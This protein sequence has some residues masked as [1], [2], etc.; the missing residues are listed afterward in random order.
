MYGAT[1]SICRLSFK[2][3]VDDDVTHPHFRIIY[4]IRPKPRPSRGKLRGYKHNSAIYYEYPGDKQPNPY[5]PQAYKHPHNAYNGYMDIMNENLVEENDGGYQVE[6]DTDEVTTETSVG[7]YIDA[8]MGNLKKNKGNREPF[9]GFG[10]E[11][12]DDDG[13]EEK[14]EEEEEDEDEDDNN[15]VD[16]YDESKYSIPVFKFVPNYNYFLTG[17]R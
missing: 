13:D 4:M 10:G 9:T 3:K 15:D 2:I 14:E 1:I 16:D 8:V 6:E 17:Y 7:G 5:R 11:D 12:G